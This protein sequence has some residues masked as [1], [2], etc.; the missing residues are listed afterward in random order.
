MEERARTDGNWLGRHPVTSIDV[1]DAML[2]AS[3]HQ[4]VRGMALTNGDTLSIIES[5]EPGRRRHLA[6]LPASLGNAA[7]A[8]LAFLVGLDGTRG[9]GGIGRLRLTFGTMDLEFMVDVTSS[10]GALSGVEVFR[11]STPA[12][13]MAEGMRLSGASSMM[14][15]YPYR[16]DGELGRGGMGVVYRAFHESLQ[17]PVAIKVLQPS[18]AQRPEDSFRFLREARAASRVRHPGVVEILDFGALLDGRGFM[19]MELVDATTLRDV[20][21]QGPMDPA[22][23]VRVLASIASAIEAAH[24]QGV[25]HRDLKPE[26]VFVLPDDEV[27]VVDFGAAKMLLASP[28]SDTA[29]GRVLGTPRY[30]APEYAWGQPTDQRTDI[31]ALGCIL[32]EMLSSEPPYDGY[33]AAEIMM[34]HARDPIPEVRADH[35]EFAQ[36]CNPIIRRAMAKRPADRYP[37]AKALQDALMQKLGEK[38]SWWQRWGIA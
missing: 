13:L 7:T 29:D 11:L 25:I 9:R 15:P 24:A 3:A 19:V 33:H 38:R 18:R 5:L 1:A 26:N 36:A 17:R 22:Q 27:K 32:F 37:T 35:G 28:P 30:M 20:L 31:Y 4:M 34:R 2:A 8:R 10:E 6:T 12:M 21:D 23:A 14:A 16:I